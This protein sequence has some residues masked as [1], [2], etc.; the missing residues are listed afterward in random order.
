MVKTRNTLF[1]HPSLDDNEPSAV[2]KRADRGTTLQTRRRG[3]RPGGGMKPD[4]GPSHQLL[5]R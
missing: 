4:T 5:V 3:V 2:S 1:I